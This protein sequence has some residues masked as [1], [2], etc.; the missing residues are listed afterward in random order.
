VSSK[1]MADESPPRH[2][3]QHPTQDHPTIL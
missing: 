3:F 2:R 1:D